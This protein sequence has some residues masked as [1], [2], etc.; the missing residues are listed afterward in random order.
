MALQLSANICQ[1]V[2]CKSLQFTET[3]RA[4]DATTNPTGWGTPNIDLSD[5]VTATLTVTSEDMPEDSVFDLLA[6]GF[7]TDDEDLIFTMSNEDL[8]FGLANTITDGSYNFLYEVTTDSQ[9]YS[10]S[11]DVLIYCNVKCAVYNMLANLQVK[12]HDCHVEDVKEALLAWTYLQSLIHAAL[13][14]DKSRFEKIL[15]ILN[16][17]TI[18]QDCGC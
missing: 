2:D 9:S 13:C 6:E 1:S 4:Y 15:K 3:T 12:C 10:V 7:P 8:N 18:N 16:K 14:G 5:A 11:V 17:I